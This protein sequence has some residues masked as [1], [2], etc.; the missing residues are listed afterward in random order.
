MRT[1]WGGMLGKGRYLASSAAQ[2]S[3]TL[4]RGRDRERARLWDPV[5]VVFLGLCSEAY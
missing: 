3:N 1:I 4:T 5:V 2:G